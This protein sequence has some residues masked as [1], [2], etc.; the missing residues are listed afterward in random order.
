MATPVRSNSRLSLAM[1]RTGQWVF[2]QDIP[3]D[4]V[5]AVCEASF[6]LHKFMLVSKSNYIRKLILESKEPDLA[7][8]NLSDLP[9]GPDIFEKTAKFCYGV[10]FEI[11]V[12]NVAALRCAA[13]YLEMTDMYCD[14]NLSS[15]TEDF[16]AQVALSSLSGAIIV[17]KSCEDL[18]P[19]AEDVKIVQRCVDVISLKACNEANF[20]S[21]TP[22]NW[23]T[24]ELSI[25]D[26]EFIGR[27]LSGMRKRGAKA[28]TLAS[29]LTTYTER[30]L[31]YLVRDHSGRCT[32]S[33][34]PGDCDMYAREREL[35]QSIVSLLPS[36]KAA[37][38][39][40]FLCCL[41][42][43][44]IF[45]KASNSC[46]NEL[47]KRISVILEHVTVDNLLVMSFTYDG[48]KLLDLESIRRIISGFMEKEKNMAVFSGGDFKETCSAA[49]HRVAK[50]VDS[51]LGEIA[52][53]PEF[54]ISKFNGIA[55]LVPK[56]AR[57]VDDD[58]YRAIDIYLKAHPN[59][60]EIER[61]KVCSVMD[62][63]KLSY[64]ARLHA[65]QNKRLPVQIVLHT[66]YYDQLKL[67][68]GADD[69]PDAAAT[70][71]ALQSDASLARENEALRSEL[72]KMK[73]HISDM[74]KNKGSSAKR[75]SAGA[76]TSGSRKH[77]FFSSMS[78]TLGKLNPFKH[79]SKDTSHIDDNNAVDITKPR[80]RRFSIS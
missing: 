49:M 62:P 9:G 66:L 79:G 39:I 18:L 57:K 40:N 12:H 76:A 77:T 67:R 80:R 43:A 24:E 74:Q 6:S 3:A 65:S 33:Y 8:I 11:T 44:A 7:R 38:P 45:V 14:N 56:G 41:L 5:V 28:L 36:E 72:T 63:L 58:I 60:D 47:E 78:K 32:M 68:S 22:P 42:R 37:L 10:N 48:E 55:I 51:Y 13:E 15:R 73:L 70:R 4:V 54:T 21:R 53:Y 71:S 17:L 16:L 52:T 75:I 2:S 26:I 30:N 29:A 35:L 59:L 19:L 46:K 27:I 34:N 31:R 20:P 69:Q 61:E 50:T 64:E 23:W 25:I 1:E